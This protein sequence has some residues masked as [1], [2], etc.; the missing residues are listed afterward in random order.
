MGATQKGTDM[1]HE[2]TLLALAIEPIKATFACR[3][4]ASETLFVPDDLE[5]VTWLVIMEGRS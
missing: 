4:S 5:L 1:T 2:N 3:S